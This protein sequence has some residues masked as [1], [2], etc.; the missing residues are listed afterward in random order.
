MM[1]TVERDACLYGPPNRVRRV[2]EWGTL[3]ETTAS[4][5]LDFSGI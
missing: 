4:N 2:E 1:F 3:D 5:I